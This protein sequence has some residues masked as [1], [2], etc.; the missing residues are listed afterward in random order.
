MFSN[1]PYSK[2]LSLRTICL[3]RLFQ[4]FCGRTTNSSNVGS[5]DRLFQALPSRCFPLRQSCVNQPELVHEIVK[6][7][8]T[9]MEYEKI[10]WIMN[11]FIPKS[12]TKTRNTI[13][14]PISCRT[15][16]AKC[17]C[18]LQVYYEYNVKGIRR[19]PWCIRVIL[20]NLDLYYSINPFHNCS[21][22]IY[23]YTWV[24]ITK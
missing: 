6:S 15:G 16:A 24:Q 10:F 2:S 9:S 22:L 7:C 1:S 14:W 12:H 5:E 20:F 19:R 18:Q 13:S 21:L 17:Q 4:N 11:Q 3:K 8:V 23:S